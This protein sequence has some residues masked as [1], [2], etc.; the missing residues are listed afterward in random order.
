MAKQRNYLLGYGE[1][2]VDDVTIKNFGS[3]KN[4]PY[5]FEEARGRMASMVTTASEAL[6]GLPE[7]ACPDGRAVAS[8]TL[9][10]EFFAKSYYPSRF[11]SAAGLRSVGSRSRT[12]TPEKWSPNSEGV[13]REPKESVTTELFVEGAR[14]SFARL[15]REIPDLGETS[16]IAGQL[17]MFERVEAVAPADRVRPLPQEQ[18][19]VALEV[20]LHASESVRDRRIVQGF[21]EFARAR[22]FDPDTDRMIYAGGLCFIRLRALPDNAKQLAQFSFLRVMREMPRLRTTQPILRGKLPGP[23]AVT[24][25]SQGPVDPN[26]R[27][28]VFDGGL[29]E[30]SPLCAWADSFDAP[31]VGDA[32]P[33]LLHHGE[34]VTS[35]VLFGST[36]A[37]TTPQ[38]YCHVD[39]YRVLDTDSETD[40]YELYDV[41]DRIETV[42]DATPYP[43]VNLSIGPDLP[44]DDD[45]VHAWTSKLDEILSDGLCLTTVAAGN[46]GHVDSDPLVQAWRVQVPSDSVNALTVGASDRRTGEW[47][48][49]PYSSRG[50]G[51]SP[52]IVKPDLVSFGGSDAEHFWVCSPGQPGLAIP[53]AGTSYAAPATMR[54]GAGIRAHFGSTLGPLAIKALLVHGTEDGGHVRDEVGWGRLP[55]DLDDLVVCPD[56]CARIVYQDKISAAKYRRIQIPM[57]TSGITGNVRIT[58][59]FC[60]T[61]D[62]DPG[63]AGNY[64]RS[65][66]E[67][68]FRPHQG[69]FSTEDS[70]EPKTAK[71]FRPA[72]LYPSEA[73]LRN[74]AHKWE[75]CLHR[76]E[77]KRASSLDRPVFDIHY[78]ARDEGHAESVSREIRYALVITVEAPRIKD[79][80]D[81]VVRAYRTKLQ[82]LKPVIEVPIRP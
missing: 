61:T 73:T 45:E 40:P 41:L 47:N 54:L 56:G 82:P 16:P 35:A 72:E 79:F 76:T 75:T 7:D 57:P 11:F 12:L 43:F 78:N 9:H 52:G 32:H 37:A 64:T 33:L 50:P 39:H 81:R 6:N 71:F 21:V 24:L 44:V 5:P 48:R 29:P 77:T 26:L 14:S 68:F 80:Y 28:A 17:S 53:T 18:E 67:V 22:N 69:R 58:A 8:F 23:K 31:G 36:D 34:T 20:V 66:L 65:G 25:A 49:A 42:L 15:A 30:S 46:T 3:P 27:V 13:P 70:I 10:P 63:H 59:T 74:D 19:P 1:R 2:L 51:R 4:P 55:D 38:P 62:V 60:F